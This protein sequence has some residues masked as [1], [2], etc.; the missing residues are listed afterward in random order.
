MMIDAAISNFSAFLRIEI[1]TA[2]FLGV[3]PVYRSGIVYYYLRF[4]YIVP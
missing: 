3:S 4:I 2:M 1:R